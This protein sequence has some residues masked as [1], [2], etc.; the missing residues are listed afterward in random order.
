MHKKIKTLKLIQHTVKINN[1]KPLSAHGLQG[2]QQY[3]LKHG[4]LSNNLDSL[5]S[6]K[7][8]I[9]AIYAIY[10][11]PVCMYQIFHIIVVLYSVH[12]IVKLYSCRPPPNK[13]DG[14]EIIYCN[15]DIVLPYQHTVS[16]RGVMFSL[17]K[18]V[19][20]FKS[21]FGRYEEQDD[22]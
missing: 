21:Y 11:G 5:Y 13:W 18:Q 15:T 1:L 17:P 22:L 8:T 20:Y 6:T 9:Y 14:Q 10:T 4:K 7:L 19:Y 2:S 16:R 3:F 12:K